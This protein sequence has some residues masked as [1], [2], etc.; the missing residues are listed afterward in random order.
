[1]KLNKDPGL[2][3]V[4]DVQRNDV[5]PISMSVYKRNSCEKLISMLVYKINSDEK[6]ISMLVYN[7]NSI[8]KR[9]I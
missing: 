1:M 9:R 4:I 6:L 8:Q 3:D 5:K 2:R 7:R